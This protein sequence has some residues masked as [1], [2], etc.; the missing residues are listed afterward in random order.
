M[1]RYVRDRGIRHVILDARWASGL[2]IVGDPAGRDHLSWQYDQE[3]RER[4]LD[5]NRRAFRRSLERTLAALHDGGHLVTIVAPVP[6]SPYPVPEMMARRRLQGRRPDDGPTLAAFETRNRVVFD[7]FRRV[8]G[9][10]TFVFPHLLLCAGG[11]PC[12]LSHGDQPLYSDNAHL[13]PFGAERISV[14][15]DPLFA[16]IAKGVSR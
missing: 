10:A 2:E 6:E 12:A 13:S 8:S 16:S 15:F 4:S 9:A 14:L 11:A 7:A 1:I 3:S 5:E